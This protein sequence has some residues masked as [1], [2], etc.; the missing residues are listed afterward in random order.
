M[1]IAIVGC[2]GI[3]NKY[4][5]FEQFAEYLSVGLAR[6]G[7]KTVVFNSHDH[8]YT[9]NS[10]K[11][12]VIERAYDPHKHM[13]SASQFVFDYLSIQ[14]AK[15]HKPEII[16]ILGYGSSAL[17]LAISRTGS[18]IVVTN[19]DGM[20]WMRAKWSRPVKAL[21]RWSE[22]LAT[23]YSDY[24]IA[25]STSI[26]DYFTNTY[27][28][29]ST[30][31]PYG[32]DVFESPN[33]SVIER[34]G[35][36]KNSY[37]LLIARFEPENN[38]HMVLEGHRSS[39][40][41]TTLVLL[42]S[43]NTKHGRSLFNEYGEDRNIQFLGGIFNPEIVNNL[44][45]YCLLYFHGH[46]V[47]GTNPALLEAMAANAPVAALD[48]GFNRSVLGDDAVYFKSSEDV[49]GLLMNITA[50]ESKKPA[51][52]RNNLEKIRTKYLWDNIINQYEE[53]FIQILNERDMH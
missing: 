21:F 13:G 10:Y 41:N 33:E 7:H 6:K 26:Q 48:N 24:L 25:D 36:K 1:K 50:L 9:E 8:P 46:S 17:P 37:S 52:T 53:F 12:V 4:G 34:Y 30:Y 27:G 22:R 14:A 32:A 42:G 2:R 28:V 20:E 16:Y 40:Q 15:A 51:W 43:H 18:A 45:H 19:M 3:P 11:G 35:L 39:G 49:K 23:K 31:I 29:K 5:G 47:G 38:I 44:R